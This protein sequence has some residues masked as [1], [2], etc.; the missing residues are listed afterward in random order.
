MGQIE[1]EADWLY[2]S[3]SFTDVAEFHLHPT[4]SYTPHAPLLDPLGRPWQVYNSLCSALEKGQKWRKILELLSGS[5]SELGPKM[6]RKG[7]QHATEKQQTIEY[8]IAYE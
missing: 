4:S 7:E 2:T 3:I 8:V 6:P 1:Y 5:G